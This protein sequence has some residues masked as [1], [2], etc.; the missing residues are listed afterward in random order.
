PALDRLQGWLTSALFEPE[1]PE[2]VMPFGIV[3]AILAHLYLL[4]IEPFGEGNGRVARMVEHQLLLHAG[5]HAVAAHQLTLQAG[6]TRTEYARQ[7]AASVK[8]GGDPIP[9]IAY[10]VRGFVDALHE[11]WAEVEQAQHQAL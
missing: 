2:E 9:F 5:L 10:Q 8:A 4:W 3:R 7:L 6:R 1:H 11:L